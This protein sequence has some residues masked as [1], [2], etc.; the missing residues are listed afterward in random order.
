M[1]NLL[2]L[3][4]LVLMMAASMW[5]GVVA[6]RVTEKGGGFAKGYFLGNRG[7][8]SWSMA[9]TATVM[10]GGTF[11]GFPAY[12]YQHGWVVA[13]WIASY[14]VVPLCTF[15]VLGKRMGQLS[16]LTGAITLPEL[17]RERFQS[18][19]LGLAASAMMIFILAFSLIAQFKGGAV[20]LQQVLPGFPG[21]ADQHWTLHDKSPAFIYGLGVFAL[22]VVSYTVYGGFLAAV[23]TD[24]FQSVLMAI[25]VLILLPLAL[26][27]SGGLQAGTAAGIQAVGNGFAFGPGS[28]E[29]PFLPLGLAFSFFCMWSIA[30]MGQPATLVRLM[31]FRDTKTLRHA[32]FL[33]AVYNALIYIPLILI[34]ICSRAILPGLDKPDEVMP[35]MA[36]GVAPPLVAGLILAAPF[37]AVMATVSGY[38]V[39]ISSA[40]VQD[41]Y[42]RLRPDA[43]DQTLRRLSHAGII[44]VACISG[45]G[46]I[47][48]PKFLQAIV[49][50][51][52]GAAA[53]AYLFPAIMASFWK[54]STGRGAL[55]SMLGGVLTVLGLYAIGWITIPNNATW[56]PVYPVGIAP[57]VWGLLVSV[58][59]G[60]VGSLTDAPPTG[61]VVE[62]LFPA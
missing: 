34:F 19:A 52:G 14:M 18:P 36:L 38:L 7:L 3:L 45:V 21:L 55:A 39:Q 6:N 22:V 13:L 10:S 59:C 31:A 47:Y 37:G 11:M 16:R 50:F 23:W 26:I 60:V 9:L 54:R 24:L 2:P 32:M 12:V 48:S 29:K 27:K 28:G 33:L 58:V 56:E 5:I 17:L 4:A 62:Q 20:I 44:V 1:P 41:V 42:H 30:G 53:C 15:A 40:L 46:T 8:G 57:F 61:E 35:R 49:V 43:P 25:G 51:T